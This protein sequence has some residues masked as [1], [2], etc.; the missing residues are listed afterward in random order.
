MNERENY[1]LP[2]T[3]RIN[4]ARIVTE[5]AYRL[6][7]WTG[8]VLAPSSNVRFLPNRNVRW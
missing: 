6:K 2:G 8:L 5:A 4:G 1:R 3:C 7:D